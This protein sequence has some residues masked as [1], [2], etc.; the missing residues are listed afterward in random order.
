MNIK[1]ELGNLETIRTVDSRL[2]S[3]NVEMTEVTGGT[4]WKEFTPAQ[5]AGTA[6]FP[7][8]K[9]FSEM[10]GLIQWYDPIDL[11]NPRL[12]K[13]AK[14]LGFYVLLDAPQMLSV[15]AA[16]NA[17]SVFGQADGAY[18][19]DGLILPGYLG[20]DILKPFLPLA[21]KGK[22][23]FPVV[24]T[25]NKSAS[26]LQ[27]LLTGA[28]LVHT[29][30]ADI[31]NRYGEQSPAK[32][33]YWQVGI[34]AS[35]SAA[36]SLRSMRPKYNRLFLLMDGFDYPNANA[37]NCSYAFDKLGHGAAACAGSSIAA[38][39]KDAASPDQDYL[40]LA[41]QAAERMKKNLNRYIT[42]L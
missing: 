33:G 37:K 35:A 22:S 1:L 27:D 29:A 17:A 16:E 40:E 38:A 41:V 8:V 13:L 31:I 23:L 12:R 24:R 4:F 7:G 21:K 28:R 25:A 10:A 32:C 34:L 15:A 30:A 11:Y 2:M 6:E 42:L 14:E 20:S 36:D 3:Y 18:P 5:I 39:W 9:D 26:E 19:C